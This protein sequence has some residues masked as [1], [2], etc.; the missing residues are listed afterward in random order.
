[1]EP[2]G[3]KPVF[4]GR[5]VR[6]DEEDWPGSG[7]WE[8]VRPL[9]A[10]CVL[11]VTPEG[12]VLLVRQFRAAARRRTLEIPAGILDVAGEEPIDCAARELYE[13]TGYRHAS[14]ELLARI[15][16]S[17]GVSTERIHVHLARTSAGAEA[18]PEDGVELVRRPL[19]E[20]V[21]TARAGA[22]EDAKTV[23][24]LLLTAARGT[25]E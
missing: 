18:E 4:R 16:P 14:I 1:M 13:E 17:P 19:A 10:A 12:D 2:S 11:P 3:S 6:V 20:M 25:P 22:L 7:T 21:A 24:A 23:V 5:W 8:V 9:D 15:L